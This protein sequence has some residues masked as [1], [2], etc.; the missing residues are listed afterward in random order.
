MSDSGAR[1]IHSGVKFHEWPSLI[2]NVYRMLKPGNGWIQLGEADC[3][4]TTLDPPSQSTLWQVVL[5][6]YGPSLTKKFSYYQRE[7]QA[8]RGTPYVT[9][10]F[11]RQLL[12]DAGFVDI[13]VSKKWLDY[14]TFTQG[15]PSLRVVDY[16]AR[17]GLKKSRAYG[18]IRAWIV[19]SD[20]CHEIHTN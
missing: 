17:S 1:H 3:T 8:Q 19:I 5:T 9:A 12:E 18:S 14:G 2:R 4:A 16:N 11:Q 13:Q 6:F 20:T 10:D 15:I 7:I